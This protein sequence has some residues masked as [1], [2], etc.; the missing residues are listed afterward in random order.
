MVECYLI[1]LWHFADGYSKNVG[2]CSVT[3]V[4]LQIANY[5]WLTANPI[6]ALF[7]VHATSG[8]KSVKKCYP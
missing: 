7:Q 1:A 6:T 8:C 4:K 2:T 5:F 3:S